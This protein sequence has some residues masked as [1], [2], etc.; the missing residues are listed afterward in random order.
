MDVYGK[1]PDSTKGNYFGCPIWGWSPLWAYCRSV[2]TV[3]HTVTY[4]YSNDGDGLDENDALVLASILRSE[5]ESGRT[6]AAVK[7]QEA[8]Y[9]AMPDR[10]CWCCNGTGRVQETTPADDSIQTDDTP[11]GAEP[12]YTGIE[13]PCYQCEGTGK[14]R[15]H[16]T[17]YQLRVQDVRE[18]CEFLEHCGGFAIW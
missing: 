1:N 2:A 17:Q 9:S 5:L 14:V 3:A 13:I 12:N 18:F 10:N 11:F 16:E 15:P 4:G 8:A 7:E 6:A